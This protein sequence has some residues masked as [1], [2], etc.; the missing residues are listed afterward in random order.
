M[1]KIP[2]QSEVRSKRVQEND[3]GVK[4]YEQRAGPKSQSKHE[5]KAICC[6]APLDEVVFWGQWEGSDHA[7]NEMFHF[8][9]F[10]SSHAGKHM[11]R[12]NVE[13]YGSF[14]A[15]SKRYEA[16]LANAPRCR[17]FLANS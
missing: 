15:N 3:H 11:I 5:V 8:D 9:C 14:L 10:G 7:W 12:A 2:G 1:L 13:R 17:T 6:H 16:F 4:P